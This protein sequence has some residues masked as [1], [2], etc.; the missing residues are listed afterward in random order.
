M[1]LRRYIVKNVLH[2]TNWYPNPWH[3]VEGIFVRD[4]FREFSQ[5]TNARLVNVQVRPSRRWFELRHIR[6]SDNESG[7]YLMTKITKSKVLECLTTLLLLLVL[8]KEKPNRYD[9][10]HV[11]IAYPLLIHYHLWKF[12][13]K[14]KV[15]ISEH[16]SAYHFNFYLPTNT[17]KL[18]G[19][20]N[21]FRHNIAVVAVS[22][23]LLNDIRRFSG[24]HSFPSFVLPN[25]I[26]T[27]NF[28]FQ[29]T[30]RHS[31][32]P[33]FFAVNVWR[34]VKDPFPLLLAVARI[35]EKGLKLR[36]L[37]GGFG[38]LLSD[39]REFVNANG[40]EEHIAFLG[41]MDKEAIADTLLHCDAYLYSSKYETFSIACAQALCCG[42]PLIGPAIPAIQEYA[43]P[44][45]AVTIPKNSPEEWL[46]GI[47]RFL[48]E[49]A[50]YNRE[51][52]SSK[53]SRRFSIENF[54][55]QYLRILEDCLD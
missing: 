55:H 32:V 36:L 7:Y 12:I 41:P 14:C 28:H 35:V 16:W 47:E 40:L 54:K 21:I 42:V 2:I 23:A 50:K 49:R 31:E 24:T 18:N 13:I 25:V 51:R 19:I 30:Y 43:G 15:I 39:M 8:Y 27:E 5:V 48:V 10:M 6:Y 29:P 11:H 1:D 17:P 9:M 38:P 46:P 3:A 22:E 44:D 20:K 33:C 53:F 26:D 52:I 34:A 4:Q 45:E 37:I